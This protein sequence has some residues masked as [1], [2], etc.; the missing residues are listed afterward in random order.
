MKLAAAKRQAEKPSVLRNEGLIPAVV[1]NKELNIPV[2]VNLRDF[3]RVFR[4]AGSSALIDLDIDGE[5]HPVLVK[6]V[7]MNKRRRVPQHVDFFAVTAGQKVQVGISLEFTGTAAGVKDGG[8]MDVQRRE[9]VIRIVPRLIPNVLEV[10][11]SELNIGDTIHIGDLVKLLP[12]EAE[13]ADE[14]ELAVVAIVPPRLA[15]DSEDEAGESAEPEVIG[16][17]ADEE[18]E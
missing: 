7:Q 9:I 16:E 8:Q 2:S 10:D 3:D 11:V 12:E 13:I 1:Y 15:T 5:M 18:S 17:T 4:S 14:L 6:A